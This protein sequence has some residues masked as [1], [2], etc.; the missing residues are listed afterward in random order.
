MCHAC[1]AVPGA[2]PGG[3]GRFPSQRRRRQARSLRAELQA[4]RARIRNSIVSLW[5]WDLGCLTYWMISPGAWEESEDLA[6]RPR[7]IGDE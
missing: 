6:G 1:A 2:G 4:C 3:S 7:D 5:P